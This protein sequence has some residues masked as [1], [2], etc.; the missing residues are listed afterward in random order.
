MPGNPMFAGPV[1]T[2]LALV[3]GMDVGTATTIGVILG[4][5]AVLSWNAYMTINTLWVQAAERY[6]AKGN[7]RMV[8]VC[9]Y[10]PSFIVS[11]VINGIPAFLIVMVGPTFGD[12]LL[13]FPQWIMIVED[14]ITHKSSLDDLPALC[15]G[16]FDHSI[17]ICKAM[18][19]ETA[20]E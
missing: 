8:R 14:L 4:S 17:T 7:I 12:W 3:S 16:I 15:Q 19:S 20:D 11:L 13:T 6:L 9:N 10:L 5:V 18:Y 1:G 2:A